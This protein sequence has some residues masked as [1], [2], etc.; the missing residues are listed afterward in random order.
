MTF[1]VKV[2]VGVKIKHPSGILCLSQ[3]W[4]YVEQNVYVSIYLPNFYGFFANYAEFI[5]R[6][7]KCD[8][9]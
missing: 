5:V 1:T 2:Q 9:L 3:T 6:K 7:Q 8:V 4:V